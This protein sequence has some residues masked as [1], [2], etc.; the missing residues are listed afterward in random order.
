VISETPGVFDNVVF[1]VKHTKT[2]SGDFR[3]VA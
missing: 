2:A 1:S 3:R